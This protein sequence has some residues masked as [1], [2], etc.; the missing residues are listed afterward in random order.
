M[1]RLGLALLAS[2]AVA[3][4]NDISPVAKVLSMLSDLQQKV[5]REG[6]VSQKE[7]SEFA[8]WC[9]DQSRNLAFELKTGASDAER[10]KAIIAKE[11]A[12]VGS[13]NTKV[14]EASA[15]LATN[16]ADLKAASWIRKNE[17]A[18]FSE[19]ERE[20]SE[21]VSMLERATAILEREMDKGG[22][23][24]L[25][26]KNAANMGE[27]FE[28]MVRA[29]MIGGQD[30][31]KLTSFVQDQQKTQ[32]TDTDDDEA[33][34]APEAAAY[35]SHSG[36][37]VDTLTGLQE[38]AEALL[39]DL[40]KRETV[41]LQHFERIKQSLDSE[42]KYGNNDL[43]EAKKGISE[44]NERKANAKGDLDVTEKNTA[45][46][47]KARA[48]LHQDCMNKAV[49]FEAETKSRGEELKAL[50]AA[51]Q[52]IKESTGADAA[53][54]FV[55]VAAKSKTTAG[56][57]FEVVRLVRDLGRTHHSMALVQLAGKMSDAMQS[58][59]A[60]EKIKGL[61]SDMIAKL[62]DQAGADATKK[63]YC[64]KELA[65]T[66]E[67]KDDKTE[68]IEV[69]TTR[70]DQ[71]SA[72]SSQLKQEVAALQV[73]LANLAKS[74]ALMDK[75]RYEE[76]AE[77]KITKADLEKGL[78][79]IKGALKLLSDY[80]GSDGKAHEA[81]EGAASGIIGMLEVIEA[82]F[83]KNLAEVMGD[84]DV[85]VANYERVT[86]ENDIEKT[87][88]VQDIKYKVAMSKQLDKTSAELISD[89]TAVK[90]ELEAVMEYLSKVKEEC[91]AKAETYEERKKRREAEIAGLKEALD[92]LEN[93]TALLQ[94]GTV[95]RTLRGGSTLS[96]DA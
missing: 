46:D 21:T 86:K 12:T 10:L 82:D 70:I 76:N 56:R 96:A 22:A 69:L 73:G 65:E 42:I 47:V 40:R 95:R 54:S 32:D 91:I 13:L 17:A 43:D 72:K 78:S 7:Y 5:I 19:E 2:S 18:D 26:L 34:D 3:E 48:T 61:I 14:E 75:I 80:Y 1:Q 27:L 28:V 79:G 36:G 35:E 77:F 88:K 81:S 52:I 84:E 41:S 33:P 64:D 60:F 89:R 83:S 39:A 59:D 9:E 68:E 66:N 20:L 58:K 23:A 4:A 62:E 93:E 31:A 85:A 16:E 25:Q 71:M 8:E 87:T 11:T 51:K 38:K 92:T 44:S 30:A 74:Q 94:Q 63:A 90:T 15:S 45:E 67:K 55:Q 24:M 37:I 6:E 53:A 29:S 49:A 57:R 50:G